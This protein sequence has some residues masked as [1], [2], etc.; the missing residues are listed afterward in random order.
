MDKELYTIGHSNHQIENFIDLLKRYAI[1]AVC[2]VRSQPYSRHNPQFNRETI[3]QRLKEQNISYIF[4]GAEL[5]A[6]SSD[7]SCSS[8]GKVQFTCLSQTS[9]FQDGIKRVKTGM[10]SYR[11]ALMC[12]EKDP[13]MCHRTMLICRS[14]RNEDT[15]IKHIMADGSIETNAEMEERLLGLLNI[16]QDD[17]FMDHEQLVNR[18][19]DMQSDKIAYIADEKQ[20]IK[21]EN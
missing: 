15:F 12:A 4:L 3:Q 1:S 5:G 21:S 11:V 2:D 8:S 13:L 20:N 7:T 14:M 6:R 10:T 9:I 17:L 19:Y 16:R 18:A